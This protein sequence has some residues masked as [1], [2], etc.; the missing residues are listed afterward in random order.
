MLNLYANLFVGV[1]L[2]KGCSHCASTMLCLCMQALYVS[3]ADNQ[4]TGQ[5]P[6]MPSVTYLNMASNR[7]TDPSYNTLPATLQVLDLANNRL[8][9]T[10]PP[11]SLAA[12][13]SL[14][15][16]DLANN[17]LSGALPDALPPNLSVLNASHNSFSGSLPSSWRSLNKMAVL[18]LDNNQLTGGQ[19]AHWQFPNPSINPS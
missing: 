2:H 3:F 13:P 19:L 15:V 10:I 6:Q 11:S 17:D 5:I 14:T 9:G 12:L 18:R 16:L 4:L 8:T 1:P 7:L